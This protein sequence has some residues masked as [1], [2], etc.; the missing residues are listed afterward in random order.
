MWGC[1]P[2][3]VAKS[4]RQ[5]SWYMLSDLIIRCEDRPAV[6]VSWPHPTAYLISL[7]QICL[8]PNVRPPDLQTDPHRP[9]VICTVRC[10]PHIKSLR[11][12]HKMKVV[13]WSTTQSVMLSMISWM[14]R[15]KIQVWL[16]DSLIRQVYEIIYKIIRKN[17]RKFKYSSVAQTFRL[18]H[19]NTWIQ[20]L[21]FVYS[22]LTCE[23][24]SMYR[25]AA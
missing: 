9:F 22:I 21:N 11:V 13:L 19:Q 20:I 17:R 14:D 25:S 16:Q 24:N 2:G 7:Q 18:G 5:S 8:N 12:L 15:F 1:P 4:F 6:I 3:F 10:S 23:I